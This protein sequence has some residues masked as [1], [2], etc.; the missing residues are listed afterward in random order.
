MKV[1][2]MTVVAHIAG[3]AAAVCVNAQ[4]NAFTNA[5]ARGV[6][7]HTNRNRNFRNNSLR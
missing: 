4:T 7:V 3:G 2:Y 1:N 5:T 6:M